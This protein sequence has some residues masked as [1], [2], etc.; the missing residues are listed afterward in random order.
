[1]SSDKM[2][3]VITPG[4]TMWRLSP[5]GG[6]RLDSTDSLALRIGGAESNTAI[7]LAR[8]GKTVCWWSRLPDNPMGLHVAQTLRRYGVDIS[9]VCWEPGARLGTYFVEFGASPRPTRVIYDRAGSAASHMQ[10][11][12]FDWSQLSQVRWLHLTGI[13]P[14]LSLSC[15]ETCR[16]AAATAQTAGVPLSFDINYRGKLWTWDQAR[17]VIDELACQ[18]TLVIGASRDARSLL[19]VSAEETPERLARQLFAR[20]DHPTIILTDGARGVTAFDGTHLHHVPAFAVQI[21][22]RLGA[23]DAF[24]AGLLAGLLDGL[25]LP[26]AIRQGNAAATIKLT[27]ADELPLISREEVDHLLNEKSTDIQR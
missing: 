27:I 25:P 24:D 16:H 9:G 23:G 5:P 20:W 11:T 19:G 4:E 15:L 17:P 10:P 3:D 12:D 13:T 14:A 7:A 18:S 1:M 21:V 6:E 8:L 2:V 22:D 26:D